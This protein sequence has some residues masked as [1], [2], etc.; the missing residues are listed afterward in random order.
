MA[1]LMELEKAAQ[2]VIDETDRLLNDEPWPVKYRAPYGAILELRQ[3]LA[4][5]YGLR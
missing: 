3:L 5:R 2:K 4:K 1:N